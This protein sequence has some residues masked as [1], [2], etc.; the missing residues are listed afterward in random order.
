MVRLAALPF[1]LARDAVHARVE[2][3]L[4]TKHDPPPDALGAAI[5]WLCLTHD[6]TGR[7]GSSKGFS[8]LFGWYPAFPETT[9]YIIGTLLGF[10]QRTGDAGCARRAVEMGD[11]ELEVQSEDGGIVEGLMDGKPRPS[12]VFNTGMVLH[13][14]LDLYESC[15]E[16]RYLDAAERAGRF[17]VGTQDEDGAWRGR[18]SY[19]GIPHVYQARVAWALLRLAQTTDDRST[20]LAAR[21]NLD[22]VLGQQRANGWFD[23]CYFKPGMLPSTHAIAY[24]LRGLLESFALLEHEPYLEA[25]WRSSEV[26]IRKLEVLDPLPATFD[27]M[28]Q[29]RARYVCLT[30]LAQLG[31]VWL[32]LFQLSGDA[33]FLN[34]GLKAVDLAAARQAR[35]WAPIRGALPGS[36]PTY[37]RYAPLQWPNWA[38]KF[39]ADGLMLREDCLREE[40]PADAGARQALIA[41]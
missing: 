4:P 12:E 32:R 21:R 22:W 8:L 18:H 35:G 23:A 27:S 1:L 30:G 24:T 29:P 13:G 28:W 39:L 15:G 6:V 2:P 26:L 7:R 17:L 36:F 31:G 11:W 9:G 16:A 40:R 20:E 5:R 19:R 38:T 14:W 34:A 3:F 10:S 33:R 25:A 41:A 37:G